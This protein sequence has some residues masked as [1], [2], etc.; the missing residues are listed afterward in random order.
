M[1]LSVHTNYASLA[2]QNQLGKTNS[3]LSTAMQRL[4]TGLRINS[5]SDDAAGLQIATRLQTQ[6]NGQKVGM[7]NAQDSISMMQTAE[8]AL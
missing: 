4:G 1:A 2:T 7:R 6:A 8:G 3:M 5:A